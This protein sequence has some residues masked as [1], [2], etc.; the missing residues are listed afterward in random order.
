LNGKQVSGFRIDNTGKMPWKCAN[1]QVTVK[2]KNK[3]INQATLLD[4]AGYAKANIQIEKV[5]DVVQIVLPANAMYLVLENTTHSGSKIKP[6]KGIKVYPNPSNGS[7][8]VDI[9]NYK[10]ANYSMELFGLRGEKIWELKDIQHA[11]FDV[12]L[13][14]ISDGMFLAVLKNEK[15]IV[16]LEKIWIHDN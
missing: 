6:E 11:S 10:P 2:L 4:A 13:K 15:G 9:L 14:N 3:S 5:G 8:R 1:T 16:E 12:N 7:F